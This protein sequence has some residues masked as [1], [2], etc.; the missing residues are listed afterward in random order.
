MRSN[1][2]PPQPHQQAHTC[3][4]ISLHSPMENF[5]TDALLKL[6][7]YVLLHT[8]QENRTQCEWD[9]RMQLQLLRLT[10]QCIAF[11]MT[12]S[13]KL[14]RSVFNDATR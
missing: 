14:G 6:C 9:F 13:L 1:T 12:W 5:A 8:V 7:R 10:P 11:V 3:T 2:P 4:S